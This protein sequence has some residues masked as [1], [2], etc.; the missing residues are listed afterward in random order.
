MCRILYLRALF[1]L[2]D[3]AKMNIKDLTCGLDFGTSNSII[4]LTDKA[5]RKEVFSYSTSSILYFP[6]TNEMKYYVGKEAHN[7]YIEEEMTGRLL[8]SVK[9]LLRQDKFLSTWIS[10]KRMTPDQLVTCI[11]RHLKEKAEAFTDTE[12]TDVILGRPAVFSEDI[13]QENLAVNRLT[14]AARNAGFKNIK[15]QLEPIAA[16]LSYEQQLDH[17]EN[18]LVADL[19]GGTSDFTIMNLSPGKIRKED[20][21]DDIIAHGGVYIGGDLFDSEIMWYKVTPHL[22]RGAKYQSYDK[23]IEVP[24][25]LYRE[26]KNWERTFMLKESKLRRSMDSYYHLSGNNPRINNVRVLID[27][28]YVFSLFKRIEQ[29][30]IN[31]SDGK[32]T[33]IDFEKDAISIHEP[34][35]PSEFATIIERHTN[36]I[37]QYLRKMLETAKYKA[38]DID[39]VFITG[40]SSL[41]IPVREILYRIFGEDK[42]RTGNTFNSVAYGLSL[43]Y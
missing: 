36:E 43:S 15:L 28:N 30:K 8:K 37:E 27:N 40:G 9:T 31:L 26:L 39:S 13:K 33:T 10:G 5:T 41:V 35:T 20:R 24:S 6:D 12:I 1:F 17:S 4:S 3:K 25:I 19:G 32:E 42:I 11:I 23:E 22:G 16:A 7:K 38:E 21:K 18:V 2:K 29:S 14:L 34:F